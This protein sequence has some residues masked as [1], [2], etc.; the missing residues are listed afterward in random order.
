MKTPRQFTIQGKTFR[1]K[2]GTVSISIYDLMSRISRLEAKAKEHGL[3]VI[4]TK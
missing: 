3:K 4:Y 1:V 2:D